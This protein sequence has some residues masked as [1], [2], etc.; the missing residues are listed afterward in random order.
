MMNSKDIILGVNLIA[1]RLDKP[2]VTLAQ[3]DKILLT[4]DETA[5]TQ[6]WRNRIETKMWNGVSDINTASAE[7]IRESNPWADVVYVLLIDGAVVFMQT[8]DPFQ[9]GWVPVTEETVDAISDAHA[10]QIAGE[11]ARSEIFDQVLNELDL[12][13]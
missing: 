12:D 7:Y 9:E 2:S 6:S 13:G 1:E 3:I 5:L 11:S 10:N 8:H 4:K